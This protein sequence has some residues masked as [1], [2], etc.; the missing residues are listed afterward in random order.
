MS[1]FNVPNVS[2]KPDLYVLD[3]STK[4]VIHVE[5]SF[6]SLVWTDRY[7]ESGDFVLTIPESDMDYSFYKRGNYLVMDEGKQPMVIE[8]I[9]STIGNEESKVEIKGRTLSSVLERRINAS[10][11][12]TVQTDSVNYSGDISDVVQSIINDEIID[13]KMQ[14]YYWRHKTDTGE[15]EDGY[16]RDHPTRNWKEIQTLDSP[17]RKIENFI[18]RNSNASGAVDKKFDKLMSVYDILVSFSKKLKTGFRVIFE[19]GNLVLETYQ[20]T[21]RTSGQKLENV[22]MFNDIMDNII[23]INSYED[24]S[25]YKNVGLAYSDGAYSPV[26]FNASFSSSIFSGYTWVVDDPDKA[27]DY[28]KGLDRFEVPFDAR[29]SASVSNWDPS[30]YYYPE[31]STEPEQSIE[32]KVKSVGDT[33]FDSGDYDFVSLTEGEIDPLVR[34]EFG[35]DYFLGDTVEITNP[36]GVVMTAIIDEVVT[37]Y[38]DSGKIVTPNFLNMEDYEY[39]DEGENSDQNGEEVA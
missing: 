36:S 16:D 34:Y 10:K 38:D 31:D 15:T 1:D 5:E 11:A 23:S 26:D 28:Y 9:D 6:S 2:T 17:E 8:S 37:S 24:Q 12:L 19:N 3:K 22:V 29:S 25:S 39:G 13:P 20:G 27:E 21:D 32:E 30:D 4:R 18:Y 35:V 33:E 14:I 7:Q